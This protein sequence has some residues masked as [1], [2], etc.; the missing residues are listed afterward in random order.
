MSEYKFLGRFNQLKSLN[1]TYR[2][3]W[4]DSRWTY[5]KKLKYKN[6]PVSKDHAK[7]FIKKFFKVGAKKYAF[8]NDLNKSLPY[9]EE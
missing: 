5:N 6:F 8:D 9:S 2:E 7:E 1:E 3:I 4:G